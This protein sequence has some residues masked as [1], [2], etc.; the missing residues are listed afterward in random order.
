PSLDREVEVLDGSE[1]A[2]LLAEVFQFDHPGRPL[3]IVGGEMLG[4]GGALARGGRQ[5]TADRVTRMSLHSDGSASSS[6]SN[7]FRRPSGRTSRGLFLSGFGKGASPT[8][9]WARTTVAPV[10]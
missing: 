6:K 10:V 5:L 4:C 7:A 2:V 9:R 1:V 8:R 3:S